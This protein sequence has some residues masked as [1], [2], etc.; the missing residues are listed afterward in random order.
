MRS[1]TFYILHYLSRLS[2]SAIVSV[3][4]PTS[5]SEFC[6]SKN[7]LFLAKT[8]KKAFLN[9]K[10]TKEMK[11]D[12]TDKSRKFCNTN[13]CIT[14]EYLLKREGFRTND[15]HIPI[16]RRL[17][18]IGEFFPTIWTCD[19]CVGDNRSELYNFFLV[20]NWNAFRIG[21]VY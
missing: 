12:T 20:W 9:A 19:D 13:D 6:N 16:I 15:S 1:R 5:S 17:I 8:K 10:G 2:D 4:S 3:S 7:S 18:T 21:L 14:M 11:T